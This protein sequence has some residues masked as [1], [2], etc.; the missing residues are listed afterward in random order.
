[1]DKLNNLRYLNLNFNYITKIE[2]L[3]N[4]RMIEEIYL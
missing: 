2:N 3:E 4:C 1:M